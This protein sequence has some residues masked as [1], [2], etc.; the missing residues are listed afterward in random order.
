MK[1]YKIKKNDALN[2][3]ESYAVNQV[4]RGLEDAIHLLKSKGDKNTIVR[5]L[6]NARDELRKAG[7]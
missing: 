2:N 5:T 6:D 1:I 7:L 3:K 4:K